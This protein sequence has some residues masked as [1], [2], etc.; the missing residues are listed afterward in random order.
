MLILLKMIVID[1]CWN[2]DDMYIIID[3]GGRWYVFRC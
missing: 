1:V 2:V 3:I